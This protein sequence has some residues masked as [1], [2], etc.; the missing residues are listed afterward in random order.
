MGPGLHDR[1][2]LVVLTFAGEHSKLPPPAAAFAEQRG[3][4][5]KLGDVVYLPSSDGQLV[6]A[7]G[8]GER[9]KFELDHLRQ[10]AAA[11]LH[12]LEKL[13]VKDAVL[14][15]P[16]ALKSVGGIHRAGAGTVREPDAIT[17]VAEGLTLG[18]Y[19]FDKYKASAKE[20]FSTS[21][22]ELAV[23]RPD[24]AA[25]RALADALTIANVVNWVRDLENDNSDDV[26]PEHVEQL[27][28]STVKY[29]RGKI[30]LTAITGDE[31]RT[32]G[33][34]LIHA[35]GRA[36]R[37]APRLLL[38]E[39]RGAGKKAPVRALV[40]KGVTFDTGGVNL[41][42]SR[43]GM[44]ES[45]HLDMSGAA[46]VLAVI[47]LAAQLKLKVNLVAAMPVVENAI[48]ANAV[49]PGAV[50]RAY[51]GQSVEIL[52]TDAEGRLIIADAIAYVADKIKPASII[53]IATLTGSI[54]KAIGE[55]IAGLIGN[56]ARTLT[57]LETSGDRTGESVWRFP[58]TDAFRARTSSKRADLGN[59]GNGDPSQADHIVATAFLEKFAKGVPYVHLDIAGAA[60]QSKPSGYLPADGTGFGVRLLLDYLRSLRR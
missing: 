1:G 55:S 8:L 42:P 27:A 30:R 44:L 29:H 34:G 24:A 40:G 19:E 54:I 46:T 41:K 48:D 36:S 39:Y 57:A 10:A 22:I 15:W 2:A 6:L 37:W 12:T 47:G 32:R 35:V 13:R 56:D 23:Q 60:M 52:N 26:N 38:L 11:A 51:G 3:F 49:K 9:K 18:A 16:L 53:S 28:R 20:K 17:A 25:K 5:G 58:L 31:L 33:L 14:T 43:G 7:I 21:T 50:V 45:M 59:L 4:K